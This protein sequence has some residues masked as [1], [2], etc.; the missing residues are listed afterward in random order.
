MSEKEQK[1][2]VFGGEALDKLREGV[3]IVAEAVKVTLGGRGRNALI[4]L[5]TYA[6]V[7]KDGVTVA[8]FVDIEDRHARQGVRLLKQ[9]AFGT[10]KE[11][12]DG[13]FAELVE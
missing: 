5:P 12:G 4:S 13:V 3:N 2:V 1:T 10:N 8:N 6:H 9:V 11:V 7:T